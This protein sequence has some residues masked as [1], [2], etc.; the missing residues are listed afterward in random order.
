[1]SGLRFYV[2]CCRNLKALKRHQRTIPLDQMT[3]VINT[4]DEEFEAE[5]SQYCANE[6]ID[7]VITESNGT[8]A[9]GKNS[10]MDLFQ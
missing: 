3:I 2:L 9:Q 8:P 5:A 4:L 7:Y 10:V 6:G 1:M